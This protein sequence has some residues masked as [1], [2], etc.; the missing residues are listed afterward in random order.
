MPARGSRAHVADI[1]LERQTMDALAGLKVL[2]LGQLIAE[3]G[4]AH[5]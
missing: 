1:H 5:V 4:R 2:E 3:I